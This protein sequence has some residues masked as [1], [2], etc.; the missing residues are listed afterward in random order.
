MDTPK[1]SLLQATLEYL[2]HAEHPVHVSD[3][4]E[5]SEKQL[6]ERPTPAALHAL[7][8]LDP[9]FEQRDRYRS[10]RIRRS[11][12]R[13]ALVTGRLGVLDCG[14]LMLSSVAWRS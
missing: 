5:R 14:L 13:Y 3:L 9:R 12:S 7:L 4:C 6:A 2:S 11:C 1:K 8:R 10:S